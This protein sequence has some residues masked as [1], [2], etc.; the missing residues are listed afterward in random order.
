MK[1]ILFRL[2]ISFLLLIS[3]IFPTFAQSCKKEA[4]AAFRPIPQLKYKCVGQDDENEEILKQPNRVKAINLFIQSLEKFTFADWWNV[5]A[6]DLDACIPSKKTE[7]G[8]RIANAELFGNSNLRVFKVLDPCYQTHYGGSNIFLLNRKNGKVY[9]SEIFDGFFNR[10]P[11]I[12]VD[13]ATNGKEQ[14]I[15]IS[16]ATSGF[17]I[18]FYTNFYFAINPKTNLAV[19]KNLFV[20]DGKPTN[21]I[22]SMMDMTDDKNLAN[23]LQI[24]LKGRLVKSFYKLIDESGNENLKKK[25]LKWNGKIYQ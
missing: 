9:V 5:P 6:K 4:K 15:E 25:T 11:D 19:S 10:N 3:A 16:Y 17:N 14:I 23:P 20:E 18:P 12:S 2:F 7:D 21:Q 13:F 8:E 24:I 22:T 1:T